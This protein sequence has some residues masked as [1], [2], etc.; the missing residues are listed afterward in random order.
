MIA[1]LMTLLHICLHVDIYNTANKYTKNHQ[2][3]LTPLSKINY[4]SLFRQLVSNF[5]F[6][7]LKPF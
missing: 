6:Y 5:I 3:Y 4:F 2:I 7:Y 1:M